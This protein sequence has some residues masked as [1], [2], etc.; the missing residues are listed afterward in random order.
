MPGWGKTIILGVEMHGTP[1]SFIAKDLI[2]GRSVSGTL[3]GGIKPQS[4]LPL[5]V[6]RYMDKELQWDDLITH[7]ADFTDINKAFDLL[8]QGKSLRCTIWMDR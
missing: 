7:E 4:D 3:L 1:V 8:T 5:L 6:K 2:M